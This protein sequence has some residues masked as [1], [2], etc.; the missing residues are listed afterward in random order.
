LGGD[1]AKKNEIKWQVI[2][3]RFFTVLEK[4]DNMTK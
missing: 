1:K 3:W 2:I 4:Y